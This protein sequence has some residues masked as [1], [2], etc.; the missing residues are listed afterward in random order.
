MVIPAEKIGHLPC[1]R[2]HTILSVL[3]LYDSLWP[4]D[5]V[6][7]RFLMA[8]VISLSDQTIITVQCKTEISPRIVTISQSDLWWDTRSVPQPRQEYPPHDLR[9]AIA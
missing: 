9:H 6:I 2:S 3:L 7:L 1:D 4:V 5:K 8:I